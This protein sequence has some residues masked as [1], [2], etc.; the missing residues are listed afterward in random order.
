MW[1][2]FFFGFWFDFKCFWILFALL[3]SD[4]F[5]MFFPLKSILSIPLFIR[6]QPNTRRNKMQ[7]YC[8]QMQTWF[9]FDAWFRS[10]T[11]CVR[12]IQ[13][14]A[15][16]YCFWTWKFRN[17]SDRMVWFQKACYFNAYCYNDCSR[18]L[19]KSP[20]LRN[21]TS[22][23]NHTVHASLSRNIII[24]KSRRIYLNI[25]FRAICQQFPFLS[26]SLSHPRN[27]FAV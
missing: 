7:C 16:K 21:K 25:S 13:F 24:K 8:K 9:S 27:S 1:N 3:F 6:I 14:F 4:S 15:L 18:W 10:P 5:A 11:I 17:R 2:S 12:F 20:T 23:E 22:R 19:F 26:P